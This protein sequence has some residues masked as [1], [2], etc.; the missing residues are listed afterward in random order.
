LTEIFVVKYNN[1][2]NNNKPHNTTRDNDKETC[3][4][5]DTAISGDINVTKK[6][7]D[8]FLKY[9]DLTTEMQ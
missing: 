7:A 2:N 9:K 4:L 8:K 3:L 6:Q 1:N 5:I